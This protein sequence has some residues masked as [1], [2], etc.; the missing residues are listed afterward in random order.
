MREKE[1]HKCVHVNK[2]GWSCRNMHTILSI[3]AKTEAGTGWK[4][5]WVSGTSGA[6]ETRCVLFCQGRVGVWIKLVFHFSKSRVKT[7]Q[8]QEFS[9]YF[10]AV[11][12][13]LRDLRGRKWSPILVAVILIVALTIS[14]S[15]IWTLIRNTSDQASPQSYGRGNSG[16]GAQHS[17]SISPPGQ[18]DAHLSENHC[19]QSWVWVWIKGCMPRGQRASMGGIPGDRSSWWREG[20]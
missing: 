18:S 1:K 16:S 6:D 5:G 8:K 11:W 7:I 20:S 15:I 4:D 2:Q 12:R 10:S 14:V 13:S 3:C 19:S 9:F 17:V